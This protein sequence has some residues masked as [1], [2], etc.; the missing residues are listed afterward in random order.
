MPIFG[1]GQQQ[2]DEQ[3]EEEG[4]EE[5]PEHPKKPRGRTKARD[6]AYVIETVRLLFSS[7]L[8]F[9]CHPRRAGT[10]AQTLHSQVTGCKPF[11]NKLRWLVL[12]PDEVGDV[13]GWSYVPSFLSPPSFPALL[14]GALTVTNAQ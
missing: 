5:V 2:R 8:L 14:T 9:L 7:I 1:S 4:Q 3:G 6:D 13:I 10:H 12:H 11:I